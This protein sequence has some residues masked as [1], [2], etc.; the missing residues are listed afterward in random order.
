MTEKYFT[1]F[2]RTKI[3]IYQ[4]LLRLYLDEIKLLMVT[5]VIP[6]LWGARE[7]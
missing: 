3:L 2:Y 5:E 4:E 6:F 7:F 1:S